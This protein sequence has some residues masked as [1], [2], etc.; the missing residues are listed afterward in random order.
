[1][2]R[3]E[4]SRRWNVMLARAPAGFAAAAVVGVV[5]LAPCP[6]EATPRYAQETKLACGRCHVDP[7]G[8][9]KLKP[10]GQEFKDNGH[11]LK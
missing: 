5:A 2:R 11:R 1:M 10:F 3:F 9:D 8:G 7:A 6:A 4:I